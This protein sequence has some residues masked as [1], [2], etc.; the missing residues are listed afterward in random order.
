MCC[1]WYPALIH[2]GL[3]GY[4]GLFHFFSNVFKDLFIMYMSTLLLSSDTSVEGIRSCYRW[5][6]ATMWLLGIELKTFGRAVI[7]LNCW[8]ISLAFSGLGLF[9][10]FLV[11]DFYCV[12]I[13]VQF[14]RKFHEPLRTWY[15]Y[16]VF[17]QNIL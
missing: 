1:F 8:V 4:S 6:W 2:Y 16:I 14:W 17:E 11:W 15:I 7:I 9:L 12:Q 3:V 13:C 10:V 5:L